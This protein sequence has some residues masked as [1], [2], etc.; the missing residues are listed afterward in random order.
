MAAPRALPRPRAHRAPPPCP[1]LPP[2][3]PPRAA[4]LPRRPAPP[5]PEPPIRLPPSPHPPRPPAHHAP[6]REEFS[7]S[8]H[9]SRRTEAS[10]RGPAGCVGARVGALGKAR[11]SVRR[12]GLK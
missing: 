1:R 11:V 8:P 6:A 2:A 12:P 5:Y 7:R 9:N 4:P 3:V 10:W